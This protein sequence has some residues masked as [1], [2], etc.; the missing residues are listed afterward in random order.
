MKVTSIIAFTH[1]TLQLIGVSFFVPLTMLGVTWENVLFWG[2]MTFFWYVPAGFVVTY[3]WIYTFGSWFLVKNHLDIQADCI[4]DMVDSL[5]NSDPVAVRLKDI[6]RIDFRYRK[7]LYRVNDFDELSRDL[8]SPYRL[9]ASYMSVVAIFAVHQQ[10]NIVLKLSLTSFSIMFYVVSLTFLSTSCTL[11]LKRRTMHSLVNRL[12]VKTVSCQQEQYSTYQE[13]T[14][15]LLIL[16]HVIKS[17]GHQSRTSISLTDTAGQELEP[18]EFI[19]FI[20]ETFSNFFLASSL[21]QD[22]SK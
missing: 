19:E 1:M 16:R 8:I 15:I 12:F 4:L 20:L 7:L 17:V 18:M 5:L 3:N 13:K 14:R 22:Y 6:A 21:Y 11:S 9:A 10:D 2:A